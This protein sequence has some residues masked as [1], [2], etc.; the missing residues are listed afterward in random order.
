MFGALR[1]RFMQDAVYEA[2]RIHLLGGWVNKDKEE[3]WNIV[4][5]ALR[6]RYVIRLAQTS[7]M[8]IFFQVP[9]VPLAVHTNSAPAES[10]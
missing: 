2:P 3:G 5:S 7:F 9:G 4:A 6:R 1:G 8:L 10:M